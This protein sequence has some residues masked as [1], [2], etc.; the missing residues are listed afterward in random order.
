MLRLKERGKQA[1]A[2]IPVF[3]F[4]TTRGNLGMNHWPKTAVTLALFAA[5]SVG[6]QNVRERQAL[7]DTMDVSALDALAT[8]FQTRFEL[9]Q[10]RVAQYLLDNPKAQRT[11]EVNGRTQT[12]VRIDADGKPVYQA[13]RDGAISSF[14]GL[15]NLAS[16]QLIKADSL[17]PGGSLGVSITGTGMVAGVWEP[18]IPRVTHELITGK[19]TVASGQAAFAVGGNADHATH[20]TGTMIG[21]NVATHPSAQGIAYSA[22]STNYD[23]TNDVA[24]MTTFAAGGGLVSNHSYGYLNDN[25]TP[26]WT[27]G[28]YDSEALAWDQLT[29]AAPNYL[30]FVAAGN[31]Q[32][33]NG[34]SGKPG[35]IAG[36]DVIT[37]ASAAKNVMTV[38]AVN[39]DK[40]IANYSNFGPTDDGRLKPDLVAKGTGIDS[41]QSTADDAYSGNGAGSSGT[42][43]S[44]PAAAASGLL[45]Q[46]YY[47]SAWG[48]YMRASTLKALMIGTAEDLGNPGPD[49]KFGWGL[50]NVEAAGNAIKRRSP[51]TS[52][53]STSYTYPAARGAIIEEITANPAAGSEMTRRF[54]AKGGEPIVA[55]MCW[56]DD[57]GTEQVSGDGTDPAA[58][59]AKYVFGFALRSHGTTNY[60]GYAEQTQH[61]LTPT[62]ANPTANATKAATSGT[63]HPNT[64]A[65]VVSNTMPVAG[66]SYT[67][68]IA[69]QTGSPAAARTVSLVVTGVANDGFIVTASAGA[70]G[71]LVCGSPAS[72]SAVVLGDATTTCAA[73][74]NAGFQTASISGCGGT[75]TAAGIN[76]YTTAA[77]TGDC[78][79]SATF[80]ASAPVNGA[81]GTANGVAVLAAP[82]A[83]LCAAGTASTVTSG[84]SSFSWTCD[85]SN[86]GAN[87][88]CSAPRQYTVTA[89]A[90]ANGTLSCTNTAVTAGATTTC[91]AAPAMGYQTTSISGC[92]GTA[93]AAGVNAYATGAVTGD[94]TV[95]AAFALIPLNGA[96]GTANGVAVLAAPSANLCAAG[97]ASMVASGA[98]SF[99]WS[100]DGANSGTNASCAAP[101][102]Y[103][104]STA[105]ASNGNVTC[106]GPVT[107]GN[108]TS[109]TATPAPG[110]VTQSISG[111]GGTPTAPG[112]N[113][114]TTGAFTAACTVT[115]TFA[116]ATVVSIP[117]LG[118]WALVLLALMLGFGTWVQLRRTM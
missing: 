71:T 112:V 50:L 29:K 16:G 55:T 65:Q 110:Y 28:A 44:T 35:Y 84:A 93:T 83:N 116:A 22:T 8:K 64:C 97:A 107:A 18:G 59:R 48:S 91:T 9:D 104:V 58:L 5:F 41:A 86:S 75:A 67:L 98:S 113:T 38:G 106:V 12:M 42:S 77:I 11:Q 92:G 76:A 15:K 2:G 26:Q 49:L 81:C 27:F 51:N 89:S 114:Y 47:N 66:N 14:N 115:A 31:E 52:P 45:L 37:G 105:A 61:W 88:S 103:P 111:C 1:A 54:R 24:E 6:A 19:A 70:N 109:C 53:A 13:T 80:V 32:Q 17:Y 20:V 99:T 30:P 72:T 60:S 102:Q 79:V 39:G 94:C 96:C 69:K 23:S 36:Y 78:T 63:A 57:E 118:Q 82:S 33:A 85:G 90:G 7:R 62:M 25:T 108:T 3:V 68:Y 56:T 74:P 10:A 101:R 46:Q 43:Y 100:C 21:R 34:N 87:A 73:T 117:T 40:T 95:T 4:D